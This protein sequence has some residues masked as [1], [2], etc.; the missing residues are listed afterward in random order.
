MV[1]YTSKGVAN[2]Y[3]SLSSLV[4]PSEN[5]R[6]LMEHPYDV[7]LDFTYDAMAMQVY[8]HRRQH[9]FFNYTDEL[10]IATTD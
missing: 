4:E 5:D 9:E 6:I 2:L 10:I 8:S 1:T 3:Q 7:T